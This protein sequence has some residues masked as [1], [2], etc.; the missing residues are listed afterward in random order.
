M[1]RQTKPA[2]THYFRTHTGDK[3]YKCDVHMIK[4]LDRDKTCSNILEHTCVHTS[5]KS[6]KCGLCG[7]GFTENYILNKY[8]RIHGDIIN[9]INVFYVTK[10]LYT[11]KAYSQRHIRTHTGDKCD[12]GF[13]ENS[14]FKVHMRMH[15]R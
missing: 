10:S 4:C 3:P 9:L 6:Y 11:V 7:R 13:T 8:I 1:F 12:K 5:D 2:A 15:Y 14:T